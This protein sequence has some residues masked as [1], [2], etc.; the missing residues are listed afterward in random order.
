MASENLKSK[1]S[2]GKNYSFRDKNKG[3]SSEVITV[4]PKMKFFRKNKKPSISVLPVELLGIGH[5]MQ[6]LGW[7]KQGN[8]YYGYYKVNG[9]LF[10]GNIKRRRGG[11]IAYVKNPPI[12]VLKSGHGPCFHYVGEGWYWIHVLKYN[13]SPIMLIRSAEKLFEDSCRDSIVKSLNSPLAVEIQ[14]EEFGEEYGYDYYEDE[15]Y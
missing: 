1:K 7:N 14:N 8:D 9:T 4:K 3:Q 6:D 11:Y 12:E 5:Q 10:Y 13:S 2:I 15:T